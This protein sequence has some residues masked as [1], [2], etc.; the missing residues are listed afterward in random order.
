MWHVRRHGDENATA[1]APVGRLLRPPP[2][3]LAQAVFRIKY[4]PEIF[5]PDGEVMDDSVRAF[6]AQFMAEFRTHLIRVLT[7]IPRGQ[8]APPTGA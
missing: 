8:E 1:K 4:S 3:G 7:V 6:L 5:A 2:G